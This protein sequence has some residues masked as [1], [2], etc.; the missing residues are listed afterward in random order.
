MNQLHLW[1]WAAR[2]AVTPAPEGKPRHL[3]MYYFDE[4]THRADLE[5]LGA[6]DSFEVI[7][8]NHGRGCVFVLVYEGDAGR[9]G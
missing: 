2:L 9:P 7:E 5:K 8:G 4:V 3:P 6:V 1:Q